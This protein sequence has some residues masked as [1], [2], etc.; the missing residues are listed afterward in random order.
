MAMG[1]EEL[2]AELMKLNMETR[3]RLAEKLILSLDAPSDEKN[4]HSEATRRQKPRPYR[5]RGGS[6]IDHHRVM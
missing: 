4:L 5:R 2:E 3:A 1:I 6:N